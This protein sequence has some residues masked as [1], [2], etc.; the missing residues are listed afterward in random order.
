MYMKSIRILNKLIL[1]DMKNRYP[2][3]PPDLLPF[4]P[5]KADSAIERIKAVIR[6][7]RLSGGQA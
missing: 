4:K 5:I 6:F 1:S 7:I 3:I 2:E